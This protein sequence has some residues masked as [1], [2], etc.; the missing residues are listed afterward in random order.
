MVD[1]L[2]VPFKRLHC[3]TV[4][5]KSS[6][7]KLQLPSSYL[8][9]PISLLFR[10]PFF[11]ENA[12]SATSPQAAAYCRSASAAGFAASDVRREFP[13]AMRNNARLVHFS[14]ALAAAVPHGSDEKM[15]GFSDFCDDF[16]GCFWCWCWWICRDWGTDIWDKKRNRARWRFRKSWGYLPI[17]MVDFMENPIQKWMMFGGTFI[18]GNLHLE[19]DWWF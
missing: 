11:V 6:Q 15:L 19:V 12:T 18:L 7:R 1:P 10:P 8:K 14:E 9:F 13:E 17:W 16:R 3:S 2:F 4:L 5:P